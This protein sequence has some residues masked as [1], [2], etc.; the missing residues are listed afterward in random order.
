MAV[1]KEEGPR[2]GIVASLAEAS[3]TGIEHG[4]N[5]YLIIRL[6]IVVGKSNNPHTLTNFIYQSIKTGKPFNL[7]QHASRYLI[8]IDDVVRLVDEM[9][10][11]TEG[12]HILNLVLDNKIKV[13][14]LAGIIE[15]VTG[16]RGN[17]KITGSGSDY[18]IDNMPVKEMIGKHFFDISAQ[19]YNYRVLH[20]YY[21]K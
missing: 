2:E 12:S 13:I 15:E 7:Y 17:Y 8:D 16:M 9:I 3:Q 21:G 6:P 19:E 11:E 14:T 10:R 5:K 4:S 1:F 18:E 20:K